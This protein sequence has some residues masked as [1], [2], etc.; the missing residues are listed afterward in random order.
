LQV[1]VQDVNKA[2][3]D[4]AQAKITELEDDAASR[5]G[6][7]AP[8]LD[9][10]QAIRRFCLDVKRYTFF[11][12]DFADKE[13]RPENYGTMQNLLDLRLIHL[14]HPSLS[15]ERHAGKRSEVYMLDLSQFSGE[16][17]KKHLRVIDLVSGVIVLK[18]TGADAEIR[19]GSTSKKLQAIFRRGPV[20]G[21]GELQPNQRPRAHQR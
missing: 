8:I 4:A 13:A 3:G 14:V 16:R 2:A 18:E 9:G 5:E 6:T 11:R 1:G 15:D 21:L 19:R 10:L 12:I 17:L 7:T 20:F